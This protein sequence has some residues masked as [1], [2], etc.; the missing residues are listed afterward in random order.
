MGVDDS[1]DSPVS[2]QIPENNGKYIIQPNLI[3]AGGQAGIFLGYNTQWGYDEESRKYRMQVIVKKPLITPDEAM[4]KTIIAEATLQGQLAEK[5]PSN[6][7]AIF[8]LVMEKGVP[9]IVLKENKGQ[10]LAEMIKANPDGLPFNQV[11]DIAE[12]LAPVF[13]DMQKNG[14]RHGD[15]KPGNILFQ[16]GWYKLCDFGNAT[17]VMEE[18][19]DI[20]GTVHFMPPEAFKEIPDLSQLDE[21]GF[22]VTLYNLLTGHVPVKR[23]DTPL[24]AMVEILQGKPIPIGHWENFVQRAE[25]EGIDV[26]A[27]QDVFEKQLGPVKENRY[28]NVVEFSNA[29]VKALTTKKEI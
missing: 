19:Q 5:Y 6:V 22:A 9:W 12:Q 13:D 16:D 3:N 10:S 2:N 17:G 26:K 29:L 1:F 18:S 7:Q 23:T 25:L 4:V 28:K 11:A 15:V 27:V 8:D 24:Q 14:L 20:K 21:Y